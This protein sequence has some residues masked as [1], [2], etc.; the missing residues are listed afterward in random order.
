MYM[1]TT[2]RKVKLEILFLTIVLMILTRK[3]FFFLLITIRIILNN[4]TREEESDTSNYVLI[5][6]TVNRTCI[7]CMTLRTRLCE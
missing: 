5:F 7:L 2:S 1:Y 6:N 3:L 4:T